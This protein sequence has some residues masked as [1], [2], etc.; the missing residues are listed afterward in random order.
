MS[1]NSFLK[2][3]KDDKQQSNDPSQRNF[4]IEFDRYFLYWLK[5]VKHSFF[6]T[7]YKT[8]EVFSLGLKEE[9]G[10]DDQLSMWITNF[11]RPMGMHS[12]KEIMWISS[13]GNLCKY[14]N[15]NQS[16]D[17]TFGEFDAT[18]IPSFTYFGSDIDSHDICIDSE[19]NPY[20]CSAAFSCVCIPSKTTGFKI[21][22]KPPWITKIVPED[23]CHLNG[24]CSR[25]GQPRYVTSV[26]QT[27]SSYGWKD[28]R[29]GRGIV[30]DIIEDRVVCTGLTMPHSPRWHNGKLWILESGTGWVGEVD[31]E[32]G[33][34]IRKTWISGF[35]RGM[36]FVGEKF[37]V[38]GS[39]DDRYEKS[40]RDLPLG[41]EMKKNGVKPKCGLTV[42]ELKNMS[43]VHSLTF[44]EGVQ[45][46][47]DICSVP[48]I[49]R[50]KIRNIGEVSLLMEHNIDY[51]KYLEFK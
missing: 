47:Y 28:N 27:D 11:M 12:D 49:K 46:F 20:F 40:F 34:F 44:N 42:I 14:Q 43:Q 51:G 5:D 23:R 35:L 19:N 25:D 1:F 29:I 10:K 37:M 24:I 4:N 22:W 9:P 18:Y 48:N 15:I 36:C 26:S 41:D 3:I 32:Q 6:L 45:E 17:S 16:I 13:S 30:Y 7:M 33:K 2:K 38:V 21:W 8:S 50:P 39:S 31:L